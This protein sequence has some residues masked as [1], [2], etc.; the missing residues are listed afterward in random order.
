MSL[1][2]VGSTECIYYYIFLKVVVV[3]FDAQQSYI[4]VFINY[5]LAGARQGGSAGGSKNACSPTCLIR[6]PPSPRIILSPSSLKALL[7]WTLIVICGLGGGNPNPLFPL[8][9]PLLL[10]LSA[11]WRQRPF[12]LVPLTTSRPQYEWSLDQRGYPACPIYLCSPPG[13]SDGTY[14]L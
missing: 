10:P 11:P 5:Y 14:H 9:P 6:I 3:Y 13:S 1:S 2:A 4:Y 8:P 7:K 12:A